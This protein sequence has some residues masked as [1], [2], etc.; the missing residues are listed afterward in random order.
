M[1][2]TGLPHYFGGPSLALG[3]Q[4]PR[5]EIYGTSPEI[6]NIDL[7]FILLGGEEVSVLDVSQRC[8]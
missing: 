8:G 2:W 5:L 3:D 7:P 4:G 1:S 6:V